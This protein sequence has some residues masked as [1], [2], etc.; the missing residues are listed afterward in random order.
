M[1]TNLALDDRLLEEALTIGGHRT[2]KE[3]V[4][5]ALV[6]YIARRRQ[7]AILDRF[8]RIGYDAS[9]DY[10]KQRRRR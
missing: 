2:K 1:P 7:A 9:Y 6:E 3:T 5:E 10:K 8:G 4:T